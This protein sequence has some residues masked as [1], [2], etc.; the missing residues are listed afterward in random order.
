MGPFFKKSADSTRTATWQ[1]YKSVPFS[2]LWS[3]YAAVFCLFAITGFFGD[4]LSLGRMPYVITSLNAVCSGLVA[5]MYLHVGTRLTPNYFV[6]VTL[7]QI[8]IWLG[9][10]STVSFLTR[11]F[12]LQPVSTESGIRFAGVVMLLLVIVSYSLF[13]RFLRGEGRET[14]RIRNELDLA[15]SIQQTLVPPIELRTAS[16]EL[17][18][19]S[20][21]SD[22]V[23][24][25]LVDALP[26]DDGSTVAYIADIAGHGLQA[27]ILMGMVKTAARTALLDSTS[28]EPHAVLPSLMERLNRVLPGVKEPQMYAT[29]AGF[30]LSPGGSVFYALAAHP[31]ILHFRM[32]LDK[33]NAVSLSA[34][35]F[36]LGLLPVTGFFSESTTLDP[37]D[38]LIAMTDGI[39]EASN[40]NEEE[41]GPDRLQDLI[42]VH[43]EDSLPVLA[44]AILSA[45][46]AFGK[47]TDDQTLLMIRRL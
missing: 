15:H 44:D 41:F 37:G 19:R 45:A 10:A 13:I 26:L 1:Y 38:L 9:F 2:R 3:L 47:Q 27:G 28:L 8:P 36:P 5:L 14:F 23:G 18:G 22:K 17:Y 31:P 34:E 16:F 24:G 29:F 33:R 6:L 30:H 21:P 25:D 11:H 32:Q 42:A 43:S 7:L 12:H 40:K 39:L 35:Q 4:M 46:R 20:D